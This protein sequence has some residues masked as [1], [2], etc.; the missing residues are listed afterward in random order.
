MANLTKSFAVG[1][2]LLSSLAI[3]HASDSLTTKNTFADQKAQMLKAQSSQKAEAL[4]EFDKNKERMDLEFSNAKAR[5]IKSFQE[6]KEKLAKIWDKPELS[7]KE[8][9]VQYSNNDNVKRKVN[10]ES[11]AVIVEVVGDNVPQKE[12]Q[13]IVKAQVNELQQQTTEDAFKKDKVLSKINAK[14]IKAE[15]EQKVIP[16]LNIDDL[17]NTAKQ[18][19]FKQDNGVKITR[20]SMTVPKNKIAQRAMIYLPDVNKVSKKWN[21]RPE[22]ILAIMHT[23]SHFNPMA[24]SH[25][26]AYG[27]MQVVPASAG[28]DVTKVYLGKESVL[29]PEI[30]FDPKLNIDIGT[31][32]INVLFTRY[33]KNVE[34]EDAKTYLAI[35]SYNGGI[36]AVAK[37]FTGKGSL[38]ALAK[39]A[40]TLDSDSIYTSLVQDFPFKET[41]NYLKKVNDKKL[42]YSKML[43]SSKI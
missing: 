40:N 43:K 34:D 36:G 1:I 7:N 19:E 28:R 6:E 33:L 38:S 39:K 26:P 14:P 41:R 17:Q 12:I 4:G 27:L 31:A 2:S 37:H 20:I 16:D 15:T 21:V 8:Q 23:E 11:G 30:L 18:S 42:Y 10:F 9:W 22:L 5:Y 35:S 29:T 13:K 24:Q 32:Y 3:A 25:I